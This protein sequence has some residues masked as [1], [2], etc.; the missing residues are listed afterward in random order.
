MNTSK[1]DIMTESTQR[2]EITYSLIVQY[3]PPPF[4]TTVTVGSYNTP[5]LPKGH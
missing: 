2:H 5:T 1:G 4:T 3:K